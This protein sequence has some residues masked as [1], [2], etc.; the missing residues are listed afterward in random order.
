[1]KHKNK[2]L[3]MRDLFHYK[4]V[5]G[6]DGKEYVTYETSNIKNYEINL[7]DDCGNFRNGID[8]TAFEAVENHVHLS[9][10]VTKH[11]FDDLCQYGKLLGELMIA[12]LKYDFPDKHFFVFVTIDLGESMIIRFHQKWE[13]E[14]PYY[15]ENTEYS[16]ECKIITFFA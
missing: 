8:R 15:S 5:I 9:D 11:N 2:A 16:N 10:K 1:M 4:C 3:K 6:E 12:K 13:N 14:S 7:F